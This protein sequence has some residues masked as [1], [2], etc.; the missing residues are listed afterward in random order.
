MSGIIVLGIDKTLEN[1]NVIGANVYILTPTN[2][3]EVLNKLSEIIEGAK[4]IIVEE[5]VPDE[6][7][8]KLTTLMS[9]VKRPPLL[10]TIPS[11]KHPRTSKLESLYEI[12]S[13]A[14]GVRL[15]W[16]TK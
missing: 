15:R 14:V 5:G 11:L 10:V 7:M 2:L 4:V 13:K 6:A 8:K 9:E 16:V 12:L 3:D 1:L